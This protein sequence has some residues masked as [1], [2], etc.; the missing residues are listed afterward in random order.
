[1]ATTLLF[2]PV[3]V[4]LFGI[5]FDLFGSKSTWLSFPPSSSALFLLR[6]LSHSAR[7][8]SPRPLDESQMTLI[9]QKTCYS[10]ALMEA[11]K[12]GIDLPIAN[13]NRDLPSSS[14]HKPQTSSPNCSHSHLHPHSH[15]LPN[16]PTSTP[17]LKHAAATSNLQSPEPTR[18]FQFCA[19]VETIDGTQLSLWNSTCNTLEVDGSSGGGPEL[20]LLFL[21]DINYIE[22]GPW[23]VFL[24]AIH[25]LM[26]F[27]KGTR[28]C[29]LDVRSSQS[30]Y[31]S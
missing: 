31:G 6:T 26:V 16:A 28:Q 14:N 17:T 23:H 4:L 25:V 7:T 5:L 15:S 12:S 19:P 10:I 20:G 21:G 27:S 29:V 3:G 1:M 30:T 8:P 22:V 9:I 24:Y 13:Q 2:H 11:K 18:N